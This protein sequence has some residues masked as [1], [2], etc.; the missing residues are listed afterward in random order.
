MQLHECATGGVGRVVARIVGHDQAQPRGDLARQAGYVQDLHGRG[1]A[2][3]HVVVGVER[4]T[5]EVPVLAELV[6]VAQE[7]ATHV[8]VGTH[9]LAGTEEIE[10]IVGDLAAGKPHLQLVTIL[11]PIRLAAQAQRA[12]RRIG[13]LH[14]H[15]QQGRLGVGIE[16]VDVAHHRP[17]RRT[18]LGVAA[19]QW[20]EQPWRAVRCLGGWRRP[21]LFVGRIVYAGRLRCQRSET[22]QSRRGSK[23]RWQGEGTRGC[24]RRALSCRRTGRSG[25]LPSPADSGWCLVSVN[26]SLQSPLHSCAWTVTSPLAASVTQRQSSQVDLD[27]PTVLSC[28]RHQ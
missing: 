5:T 9:F 10:V 23:G 22:E 7:V 20:H 8:F 13:A 1:I 26:S 28:R 21:F 12:R 17:Q 4:L 19:D 15:R 27:K 6:L 11:V 25:N 14:L 3:F 16:G 24:H 2:T 18:E